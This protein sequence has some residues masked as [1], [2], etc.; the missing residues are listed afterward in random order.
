V[1]PWGV[2]VYGSWIGVDIFGKTFEKMKVKNQVL[3]NEQRFENDETYF[4]FL[5]VF[6]LSS[7]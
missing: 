5:G 4:P 2:G 6:L 3:Y 1:K 7:G